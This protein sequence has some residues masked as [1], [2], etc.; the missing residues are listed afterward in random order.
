MKLF[1]GNANVPLSNKVADHLQ[2]TLGKAVVGSFSDGETMVEVM[3]NEN[4]INKSFNIGF[5][6]Y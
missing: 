5:I 3:E 2:T 6:S 4:V 1:T